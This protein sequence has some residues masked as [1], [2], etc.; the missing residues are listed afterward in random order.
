VLGAGEL[1]DGF[2][3]EAGAGVSGVLVVVVV[4][5]DSVC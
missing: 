1:F 5:T 3:A 4:V 2:A